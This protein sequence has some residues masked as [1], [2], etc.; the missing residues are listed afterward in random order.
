MA[1]QFSNVEAYER[2]M[3]RWSRRLAPLFVE[4]AGVQDGDRV[5]DVGCGTGSL[6]LAVASVTRLSEIVGIDPSAS[7]IEYARSRAKGPRI[8]L[9]IG[10]ALRLPY[11]DASFEKCLSLLVIQFIADARR[12]VA[13]MRRVTRLGE[14][15]AAC[16]WDR[17]S[18]QFSS[19]F[20]DAAVELDPSA[21][22]RWDPRACRRGQL[23]ALWHEGGLRNGEETAL[24]IP[25]EFASFDDYWTPILGMQGSSASYF[26]SLPAA[27]QV[28]LRERLREKLLGN[29]PDRPFTLQARAWAVRGIC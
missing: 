16:V 7:F 15:V 5:L 14:V 2:Y 6:S 17:D 8:T 4:F 26:A 27:D 13:E 20:W 24:V 1:V 23:S 28:A 25:L 21:S 22:T 10:D 19:V 18:M 12:A 11:P 29:G 3:G 9:D